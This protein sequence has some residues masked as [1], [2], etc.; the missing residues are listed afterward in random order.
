MAKPQRPIQYCDFYV[1]LNS[2][3]P[4]AYYPGYFPNGFYFQRC[5]WI[6]EDFCYP[7][8][9][10]FNRNVEKWQICYLEGIIFIDEGLDFSVES[11]WSV[12]DSIKRLI[13][14]E[15]PHHKF[16]LP[17]FLGVVYQKGLIKSQLRGYLEKK[18][19]ERAANKIKSWW[20]ELFWNPN[21]KVGRKRLERSFEND[22]YSVW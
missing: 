21:T 12:S 13:T 18:R 1:R 16:E 10:R 20:V 14:R 3:R 2:A 6:D 4:S 15:E 19:L 5:K 9:V 17:G 7:P 8:T 11:K 22:E